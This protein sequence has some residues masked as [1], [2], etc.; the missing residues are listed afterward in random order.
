[1]QLFSRGHHSK[2]HFTQHL[3]L[4]QV[5]SKTVVKNFPKAS[6]F[7]V[8]IFSWTDFL[9]WL[10]RGFLGAFLIQMIPKCPGSAPGSPQLA[11]RKLPGSHQE[12]PRKPPGSPYEA[13]RKSSGIPPK[14]QRK[15]IHEKIRLQTS[16]EIYQIYHTKYVFSLFVFKKTKRPIYLHQASCRTPL[17]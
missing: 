6:F 9:S 17:T 11:P 1:M 16:A 12:A 15:S 5:F 3:F 8:S 13:P 14:N 10:P 2:M 4:Q 7:Q